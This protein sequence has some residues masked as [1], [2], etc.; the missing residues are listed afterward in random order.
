MEQVASGDGSQTTE[1]EH[2]KDRMYGQYKGSDRKG[3][4]L[5]QVNKIKYL[6]VTIS[7][8]GDSATA[9]RAR[10]AAA[11]AKWRK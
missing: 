9:V 3:E 5:K 2:I 7:K 8:K 10:V 4:K 1:S 6:G 11:R